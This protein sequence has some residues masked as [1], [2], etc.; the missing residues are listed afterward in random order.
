M[1]ISH[2]PF[3][4]AEHEFGGTELMARMFESEVLPNF[5]IFKEYICVCIPGYLP[6]Y[7]MTRI[8]SPRVK[9]ILWV[10]NLLNQFGGN[11]IHK[12]FNNEH[13]AKNTLYKVITVSEYAKQEILKTSILK[14]E[15]ILVINNAIVPLNPV[16]D[17]FKN[18]KKV[19][20]I[21]TSTASRGMKMLLE[22]LQYVTEDFELNIFNDF[23]PDKP[24]DFHVNGVDDP[25]INFYGK[26]P[27]K[28]VYKFLEE[29][30]IFAYPLS[31][32]D[33]TFCISLAEAMS[34]GCYSVITDRSALKDI[35]LGYGTIL[36]YENITPEIYGKTLNET[37]KNIK[38]NG[39]DYE[40][41]VNDTNNAFGKDN[42]IIQWETFAKSLPEL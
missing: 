22:S 35:S 10:H 36:N 7:D 33:E 26:T 19:K 20:L 8:D 25:R 39:Y 40:T 13:F 11:G 6:S 15:Q 12:I 24:H 31:E 14:P 4:Y 37:I 29:S 32:F 9:T 34:A 2:K 41:Q 23:Y 21:H 1:T 27:R 18:I 28:T 38:Q 17:K 42:V 5:P 3:A 16:K 30:H